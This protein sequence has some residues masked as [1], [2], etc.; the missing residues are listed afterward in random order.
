MENIIFD[1]FREYTLNKYPTHKKGNIKFKFA[2]SVY[3]I[4]NTVNTESNNTILLFLINLQKA[5]I[6]A[7]D[8]NKLNRYQ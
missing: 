3:G 2:I 5:K 6:M 1:F 4:N 7:K 8:I